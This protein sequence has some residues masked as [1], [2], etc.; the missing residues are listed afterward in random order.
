MILFLGI[1]AV[2]A[3]IPRFG[4][5]ENEQLAKSDSDYY[6]DMAEYFSG[7]QE[8]PDPRY[9]DPGNPRSHHYIRVFFPFLAGHLGHELL[10]DDYRTAFSL[11]NV[12]AAWLIALLLYQ[13][14][15][16]RRPDF[17]HPWVPGLL[18]L[19]SFP[20]M[21]WGYHVLT[22]T[23][24]YAT[25]LAATLA[26]VHLVDIHQADPPA[27]FRTKALWLGLVVILQSLAFLTRQTAWITV[28]AVAFVLVFRGTWRVSPRFALGLM[29]ALILA[30]V[31]HSLYVHWYHLE[32]LGIP[33]RPATI[34]DPW[35][36]VDTLVKSGF[37]FH[38]AWIPALLV[39]MRKGFH[40]VPDVVLG[41]SLGALFYMGAGYLLNSH[42]M[43]GY[44]LRLT[45]ALFPLVLLLVATFFERFDRS[46]LALPAF[47][48]AYAAIGL[49]G[50][51]LDPARGGIRVFDLLS[52]I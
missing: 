15:A 19:V 13:L 41:W 33:L 26:A 16:T 32:G 9:V 48:V 38:L 30:K 10:G 22:D 51:H 47:C 1:V 43:I 8:R 31:P 18:F 29:A 6:L 37:A 49:L 7:G 11:L 25:T 39:L 23:M 12:L 4:S 52:A 40:R 24:G 42:E 45:F 3:S 21:N 34:L 44:P 5:R 28:V 20:Q 2:A 36:V 35:Y 14:V 50:V 46:R 17:D 27:S